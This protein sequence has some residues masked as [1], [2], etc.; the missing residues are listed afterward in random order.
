MIL[1]RTSVFS[2]DF[3]VY[4]T[5]SSASTLFAKRDRTTNN[6]GYQINKT[7]SNEIEVQLISTG[8]NL[9]TVRTV[10]TLTLNQFTHVA[11]TFSGNSNAS[12]VK[13]Y[14]D[15]TLQTLTTVSNSLTT[16]ILRTTLTPKIGV[17]NETT[18]DTAVENY[19][20]GKIT[21]FKFWYT[22]LTSGQITEIFN[23]G[24]DTTLDY[25]TMPSGIY[26][27][28]CEVH[29]PVF[30]DVWDGSKWDVLNAINKEYTYF[31]GINESVDIFSAYSSLSA[32]TTGSIIQNIFLTNA[33]SAALKCVFGFDNTA[34]TT[35]LNIF[36]TSSN[37]RIF[38]RISEVIQ[39]DFITTGSPIKDGVWYNI[40]VTQDGVEP[41]LYINGVLQ[42]MTLTV[43]TNKTIW[44]NSLTLNN[45]YIGRRQLG[46]YSQGYIQNTATVDR[47]ITQT[48]VNEVVALGR[49]NPDYSALSFASDLV[50]WWK[51]NA[52]NPP[53]E[54]SAN[55]GT[56]LNMDSS[57]II[58][59]DMISVNL[60]EAD[61]EIDN[62]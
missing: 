43:T 33:S 6:R 10:G 7:S 11:V 52:L 41:K 28:E 61:K 37:V 53:D 62:I 50:N 27:K 15:S 56:S 44:F 14:F 21:H 31:D 49:T 20:S 35:S 19:F 16:T 54:I 23:H 3:W 60:V 5:S 26:P 8:S 17:N 1:E 45:G 46:N 57:N 47:D 40:I 4:P 59:N 30:P 58:T 29:Y 51:L 32:L 25:S 48:E 39:W 36:I 18:T 22:E 12:G 2:V 55:N 42:T 34:S 9:I 24:Y 38:C 13:V